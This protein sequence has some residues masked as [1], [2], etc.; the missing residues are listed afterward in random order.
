[1]SRPKLPQPAR[2]ALRRQQ[3]NAGFLLAIGISLTGLSLTTVTLAAGLLPRGGTYVTGT[4]TIASQGNGLVITQ[5]GATRGVIEW[6]SFSIGKTNS[7]TFNNGAGATLNRVTGGSPSAILGSLSATGSLYVINP[8]GIV[9]GPSGTITTSG[10]FVASTLD[11][12]NDAFMQGSGSLTLSGS[13]N[14]AV[15]NLGKISSSGGD[16]FLIARHAVINAGTVAVPNGTAE[17]AAGEQM[18]LQDSAGSRQVFVQT[19]S[20]GRVVNKGEITAAQISLQAADGNVYALAGKHNVIRASGTATRDGHVWLVADSGTVTQSGAIRATNADGQGGTVDTTAQNV[21]FGNGDRSGYFHKPFVTAALWNISAATFTVNDAASGAMSRSLNAGTSIDLATTGAHGSS[22]DLNVASNIHWQGPASLS[23]AAYHNLTIAPN[24][25]LS[26][27]GGGN[28]TLN[29]DALALGNGGSVTNLGTV[30]WSK[31]TGIVTALY[32]M[33]AYGG[34]FTPG[35][36]LSNAAWSVPPNSGLVTQITAYRL[37]NSLTDLQSVSADLAGNYAIGKDIDASASTNSGF[38]PLGNYST[39][40][41]G[42]FDGRG[43]QIQSLRLAQSVDGGVSQPPFTLQAEGLFGVIG[44]AGVVRNIAVNGSINSYGTYGGFGILAGVNEGTIVRGASSGSISLVGSAYDASSGGLVGMNLGTVARSSSS[45]GVYAEG[46]PGG[47]VGDNEL[48]GVIEQS[49]ASGAV[50]AVAHTV[51]GGGLAGGNEGTITQSYATGAV[52]FQPDYCG[53]T[54]YACLSGGAGLVASNSGKI[55]QSFA[56]GQ[57]TQAGLPGQIPPSIGI[58]SSNTGTIG[59]DVYWNKD[60]TG[61]NIGVYSGTAMP[62]ANGLTSAQMSMP[63]SFVGYD[64]EPNGV[65]SMPAG[66]T[67][68]VLSWQLAP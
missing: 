38:V 1:M 16:V 3:S 6:N 43:H 46:L 67:H 10:R 15:I 63:S 49:Y 53:G 4:G 35:T 54:S 26:N 34:S 39:P 55:T 28:L 24:T 18:L 2:R 32:D 62:A 36:L 9:V 52:A 17:L 51:G 37:V 60:T 5:P 56:T 13:S 59:S 50:T 31:S 47:L 48:G 30:D 61:A 40:F 57:V 58:A 64:F 12:C 23:L 20:Q 29:G 25:T 45:V 44:S 66:A 22:G 65:W 27:S 11:I 68:P 42:Q 19:G 41:S 7:V 33:G 14:A 8:Q 21:S